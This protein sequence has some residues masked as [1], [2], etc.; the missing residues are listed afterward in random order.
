[1]AA[2]L[3]QSAPEPERRVIDTIVP[4]DFRDFAVRYATSPEIGPIGTYL[5]DHT[6]EEI[7]DKVE[8]V[9]L[10]GCGVL[11]AAACFTF[12]ESR[13]DTN[14]TCK[15]DSV[16]VRP[17]VRK[18]GLGGLL[19]AE[20]FRCFTAPDMARKVNHL[21][22]HSV[23][24]ATVNLLNRLCFDKPA[25]LR[26]G[27]P[28]SSL[29]LTDENKPKFSITCLERVNRTGGRLRLQCQFC[30][31]RDRRARPWRGRKSPPS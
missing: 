12:V 23:H 24:P 14:Y 8:L 4:Q 30:T 27:S 11:C 18:Q 17:D 5:D 6:T 21:F 25:E 31:S 7:R 13:L 22:A 19:I 20:G 2:P 3:P 9:G 10:L 1:M 28:I 15:L 16:I 29:K 26:G